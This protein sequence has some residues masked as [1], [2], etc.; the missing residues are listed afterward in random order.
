MAVWVTSSRGRWSSRSATS[1]AQTPKTSMGANWRARVTPSGTGALVRRRTSQSWP[2]C[3]IQVPVEETR[4]PNRNNRKLRTSRERKVR[5][6]GGPPARA[7][8]G[9]RAHGSS[10]LPEDRH[11]LG[12]GVVQVLAHDPA[13]PDLLQLPE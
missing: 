4:W 13:D 9:N 6:L 12:V 8:S 2:T 3:C 1:P 7:G 10:D 11:H 5:S